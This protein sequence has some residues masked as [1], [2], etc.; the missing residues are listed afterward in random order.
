MDLGNIINFNTFINN[1]I[2]EFKI[3][4][5]CTQEDFNEE[6]Y[7]M[8]ALFKAL[9][10][11][12]IRDYYNIDYDP[13][14]KQI[15]I[16]EINNVLDHG[17][18]KDS[19]YND[20]T[21]DVLQKLYGYQHVYFNTLARL[22]TNTKFNQIKNEAN[23]SFYIL[24]YSL[25]LK[26]LY[27]LR[28][29]L[30]NKHQDMFL[31]ILSD[32]DNL[33]PNKIFIKINYEMNH[34]RYIANCLLNVL[35]GVPYYN[36]SVISDGNFYVCGEPR[37]SDYSFN[38]LSNGNDIINPIFIDDNTKKSRTLWFVSNEIVIQNGELVDNRPEL[39]NI[40]VLEAGA[41]PKFSYVSDIES[42]NA[43]KGIIMGIPTNI[44]ENNN[45]KLFKSLLPVQ[46][47]FIPLYLLEKQLGG[48]INDTYVFGDIVR[49]SK[50]KFDGDKNI[51]IRDRIVPEIQYFNNTG[52][53]TL[54]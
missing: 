24:I 26:S 34:P 11:F 5:Y 1:I 32:F 23:S 42:D 3:K 43:K 29:D 12:E 18:T 49:G 45:K 54:Y 39:C 36:C 47:K 8:N 30:V 28:Q 52:K 40:Y 41:S 13:E 16:N 2:S 44:K 33:I 51:I 35:L 20:S 50:V 22:K 17:I 19:V 9:M 27:S 4:I 53:G 48:K 15:T 31:K 10:L 7:V 14:I 6:Y 38:T 25:F 21:Y 37:E 46:K